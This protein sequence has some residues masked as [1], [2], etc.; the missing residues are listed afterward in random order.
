MLEKIWKIIRLKHLGANNMVASKASPVESIQ[1]SFDE[2]T[3]DA[4]NAAKIEERIT[5]TTSITNLKA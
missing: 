5:L 2:G 4:S 1:E 3:Y